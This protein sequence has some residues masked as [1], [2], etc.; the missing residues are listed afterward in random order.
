[1]SSSEGTPTGSGR[2]VVHAEGAS[3]DVTDAYLRPVS[4]G[5]AHDDLSIDVPPGAYRVNAR[6]S[7]NEATETVVVRAGQTRELTMDVPFDAA[8]P[9]AGTATS[10]EAHGT[11]AEELTASPAPEGRS[12]LVLLLRGLRDRAM[13]PLVEAPTIHEAGG[14]PVEVP[15]PHE[16]PPTG[17]GN[18]VLGWSL[19]LPPGGYRIAWSTGTGQDVEQ[20]VW[21]SDGWQTVLFVPQGPKGPIPSAMSL[22]LVA[23]GQAWSPSDPASR[24]VELSHARLRSRPGNLTEKEWR[25]NLAS[26]SPALTLLTLHEL[27]RATKGGLPEE[28]QE[29]MVASVQRLRSELGDH[30]DVLAALVA[31]QEDDS[32]VEVPW[33]PMLC[34]SADLVLEADRTTPT[35]VPDGSFTEQATGQRLTSAPWLLWSPAG[36]DSENVAAARV[37]GLT[38]EVA[39]RL[40]LSLGDAAQ[41]LG[42]EEIGRRLGMTTRL[43]EKCMSTL[44]YAT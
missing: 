36:S 22:H 43:V 17:N 7:G 15:V 31:L 10:N 33:P 4:A 2:L 32:G 27:L 9:V 19:A 34:T 6:I 20:S 16:G 13:A 23:T 41:H 39:S 29:Q 5:S 42:A 28:Q 14:R 37:D 1:M 30:P 26:A 40:D 8:A 11:L 12:R 35:V 25:D 44:P 38:S 21:V 3:I 24:E 18:R